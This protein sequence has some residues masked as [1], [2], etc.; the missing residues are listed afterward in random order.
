MQT[1]M[2]VGAAVVLF[3]TVSLGI[4]MHELTHA[5]V[6]HCL[7]IPYEIHWLP[8]RHTAGYLGVFGTWAVVTPQTVSADTPAWG[9]RLSAIAPLS[10][11]L[12]FVLVTVGVVPDPL[13]SGNQ[14]LGAVTIGWLACALPSP[15][16]FAVF[17]Y[18][19]RA[20]EKL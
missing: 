11:A 15:Q 12:P 10:L 4:V 1:T 8:A 19:H 5:L 9:L 7:G 17:W 20:L 6:L 14:V 16:D 2:L 13:T 3:C 18:A